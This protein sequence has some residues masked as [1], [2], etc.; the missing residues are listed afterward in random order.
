VP[1]AARQLVARFRQEISEVIHGRDDRLLVVV[2]PC[3]IH[4]HEEAVEYARLLKGE[5]D[6]YAKELVIVMRVYFEKP[7]T[8][9]GWKGYIN[10]PHLDGSFA[11]NEGLG[12]AR[13]L[14]LD[15]LDLGLP[16]GTEFLDLLTPQFFSDL[17]SWGAIGART[18]ESQSHRQLASG[19]SCPVGFKNG[20]ECSIKVAVDA[21][22]AAK[23]KH[24]FIGMT[25]FGQSAIFET[26]GN[27]DCHII[28]RGGEI[29]NYDSDSIDAACAML[30]K[31]GLTQRL[32]IDA[33]HANSSKDHAKQISV[34]D[35]IGTQL[36]AGSGSI[37]GLMLESHL[38]EGRQD[39]V[40][41][42]PLRKGVSITDACLSFEQTKPLLG[43]LAN[44]I[45]NRRIKKRN[46]EHK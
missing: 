28:L 46:A 13:E 10:D 41:G 7:R 5:A 2:G 43:R 6:R 24:A 44:V 40:P 45:S 9:V 18:T 38:A 11:I 1:A 23:A 37:M 17:V 39:L 21:L 8:T 15:I 42:T 20:T 27:Q 29:P 14:L 34:S 25:K 4:N 16:V 26:R 12:M 31:A 3:S 32:M 19:L 36:A 22:L 30:K 33:S 35:A